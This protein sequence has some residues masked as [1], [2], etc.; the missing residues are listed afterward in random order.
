MGSYGRTAIHI[1]VTLLGG[2]L[3]VIGWI[4]SH[5]PLS[6]RASEF[7]A[8]PGGFQAAG[9]DLEN[10]GLFPIRLTGISVQGGRVEPTYVLAVTST[11][12]SP[13]SIPFGL[14]PGNYV[15]YELRRQVIPPAKP[16]FPRMG[17]VFGWRLRDAIPNTV[18]LH[19]RYLGWPMRLGI[20]PETR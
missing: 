14:S 6:S 10:L 12:G 8:V 18:I 5:P 3:L 19:Y 20:H 11:E 2:Y 17:V 1:A 4:T 9:F 15:S 13:S 7:G 16:G